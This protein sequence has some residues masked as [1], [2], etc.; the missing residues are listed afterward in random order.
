MLNWKPR[1]LCFD[2]ALISPCQS[3]QLWGESKT[4]SA[5]SRRQMA[6]N[7]TNRSRSQRNSDT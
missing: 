5:Y 3:Q 4:R 1:T 2:A 6:I 7:A